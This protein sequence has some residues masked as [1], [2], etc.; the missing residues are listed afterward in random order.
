MLG[1][2]LLPPPMTAAASDPKANIARD[3]ESVATRAVQL[4]IQELIRDR[5]L[6]ETGQRDCG[7]VVIGEYSARDRGCG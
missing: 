6:P 4:A 3:L 5:P 1:Y 7:H 2:G